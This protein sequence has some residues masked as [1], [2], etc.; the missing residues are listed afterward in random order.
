MGVEASVC[1]V[2]IGCFGRGWLLVGLD[3]D[4][5]LSLCFCLGMD[6][7]EV[8]L[9]SFFFSFSFYPPRSGVVHSLTRCNLSTLLFT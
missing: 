2:C 5:V 3:D 7:R 4:V 8:V 1:K 6:A 9:G